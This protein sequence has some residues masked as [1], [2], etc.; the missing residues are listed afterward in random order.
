MTVAS[1]EGLCE[2]CTCTRLDLSFQ[3]LAGRRHVRAGVEVKG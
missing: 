1:A 3:P 2:T